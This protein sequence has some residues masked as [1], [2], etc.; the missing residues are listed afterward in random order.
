MDYTV[1][2]EKE[3]IDFLKAHSKKKKKVYIAFYGGGMN[4]CWNL[5]AFNLMV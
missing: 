5:N 2:K 4:H 3:A 1:L